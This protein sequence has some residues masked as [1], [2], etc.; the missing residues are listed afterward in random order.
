MA[1]RNKFVQG[2]CGDRAS[3]KPPKVTPWNSIVI[4]KSPPTSTR[5]LKK[6]MSVEDPKESPAV[7][8]HVTGPRVGSLLEQR[9]RASVDSSSTFETAVLAQQAIA[10]SSPHRHPT[11][12]VWVPRSSSATLPLRDDL[13]RDIST[14][15]PVVQM[16]PPRVSLDSLTAPHLV[17]LALSPLPPLPHPH[18]IHALAL[19]LN[20]PTTPDPWPAIRSTLQHTPLPFLARLHAFDVG[21]VPS[22]KVA[23][24]HK[25]VGEGVSAWEG[26]RGEGVRGRVGGPLPAELALWDWIVV[27]EATLYR[28]WMESLVR[29]TE[30]NNNNNDDDDDRKTAGH[31]A[32]PLTPPS[33]PLPPVTAPPLPMITAKPTESP[34]PNP[35]ALGGGG[36]LLH[37]EALLSAMAMEARKAISAA[38]MAREELG[39]ALV[40]KA[41][42]VEVAQQALEKAEAQSAASAALT[43]ELAA[44]RREKARAE[45]E[46]GELRV[47]C[48][49][50][51]AATSAAQR[52]E[53][54]AEGL[55]GAQMVVMEN[56]T[57]T[58]RTAVAAISEERD[59]LAAKVEELEQEVGEWRSRASMLS[60][61]SRELEE[62]LILLGRDAEGASGD[63]R[64]NL[65]R[66]QRGE[67]ALAAAQAHAT[68]AAAAAEARML[69]LE[70]RAR[71]LERAL[72]C[73][74]AEKNVALEAMALANKECA[75]FELSTTRE[76]ETSE[77]LRGE[78]KAAKEAHE[79]RVAEL[80]GE[81]G[82]LGEAL[83]A[84]SEELVSEREGRSRGERE[85]SKLGERLTSHKVELEALRGELEASRRT[86][87]EEGSAGRA[88]VARAEEKAREAVAT[89]V[90]AGEEAGRLRMELAA[91]ER[92]RGEAVAR[93]E[94]GVAAAK[95]AGEAAVASVEARISAYA[96]EAATAREDLQASLQRGLELSTL[97]TSAAV[98]DASVAE[99]TA[100]LSRETSENAALVREL[101]SS[102]ARAVE[103]AESAETGFGGAMKEW[104]SKMKE[105]QREGERAVAELSTKLGAALKRAEM[106]EATSKANA[107][108]REAEIHALTARLAHLSN[109]E[110]ARIK[111][112]GGSLKGTISKED[113]HTAAL[114]FSPTGHR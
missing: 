49:T 8:P 40:E 111:A 43:V 48:S 87:E 11:P 31:H 20:F 1:A 61:K 14:F 32:D 16:Y 101:Q 26:S 112:A 33:P 27:T 6:R 74:T 70:E 19:L 91:A 107:M 5:L 47:R 104:E 34:P 18:L 88:C 46:L 100:R 85:I 12:S 56:L 41:T 54:A 102:L 114:V 108:A 72:S 109:A 60:K 44:L 71:S 77:R 10:Q 113:L 62:S 51:E 93:G 45:K 80:E 67:A 94:A 29:S 78:A 90:A 50:L 17:E 15:I 22:D 89:A 25:L 106:A 55:V 105:L 24:L 63:A 73:V 23:A 64:E 13:A 79:S 95:K 96:E 65:A 99:V 7:N 84:A 30:N 58:S 52:S 36:Q 42:A 9:L 69:T 103:R 4:P 76:K 97:L 98:R 68:A 2:L 38:G 59:R 35:T 21:S 37:R 83:G 28:N 75:A 86:R 81:V 39:E 66:A 53:G 57:L 3:P 110:A 92:L 82:R